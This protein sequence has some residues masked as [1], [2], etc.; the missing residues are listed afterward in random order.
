MDFRAIKQHFTLGLF[1]F[2]Q[3][4]IY[5]PFI[6]GLNIAPTHLASLVLRTEASLLKY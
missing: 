4:F 3:S 2:F 1:S 6:S 5:F